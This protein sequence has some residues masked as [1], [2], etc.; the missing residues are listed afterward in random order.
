A[1][2]PPGDNPIGPDQDGA[3]VRNAAELRPREPR[4]EQVA[5]DMAD[6]DS[7]DRQIVGG[8]DR[9]GGCAPVLPVFAGDEQET[10]GRDEILQRPT[11]AR[12][13]VD[14]GVRQWAARTRARLVE[15]DIVDRLPYVA[16]ASGS[17][18]Q[19]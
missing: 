9:G 6:A 4:V 1:G 13:V 7:I 15:A 5:V 10:A 12:L 18:D 14:P 11:L 8:R 19:A 17:G 16:D 3:F 2:A